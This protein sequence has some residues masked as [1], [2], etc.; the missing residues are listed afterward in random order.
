MRPLPVRVVQSQPTEFSF[1]GNRE[2]SGE[3][4]CTFRVKMPPPER[5]KVCA[6]PSSRHNPRLCFL[7]SQMVSL[8]LVEILRFFVFVFVSENTLNVAKCITTLASIWYCFIP[9]FL[10][11][12]CI[13]LNLIHP[14]PAHDHVHWGRL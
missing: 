12:W 2:R 14:E 5:R 11:P 13:C 4:L 6:H 8:L 10:T 3:P 9:F 1:F 7:Y